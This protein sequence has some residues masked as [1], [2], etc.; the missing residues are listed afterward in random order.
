[1]TLA[2]LKD[3]VYKA[4]EVLVTARG[5]DRKIAR[6]NVEVSITAYYCIIVKPYYYIW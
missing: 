1:M 6:H 5:D 2:V 3:A 4:T